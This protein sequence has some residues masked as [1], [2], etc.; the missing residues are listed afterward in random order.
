MLS[1]GMRTTLQDVASDCLHHRLAR[2]LPSSVWLP[3]APIRVP[4]A[5]AAARA[6]RQR[7]FGSRLH[8]SAYRCIESLLLH[9][10][11]SAARC[12]SDDATHTQAAAARCS[13]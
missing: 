4:A 10:L 2:C 1:L 5:A 8:R 12:C 13:H 3:L 9:T 7:L 6:L 11:C